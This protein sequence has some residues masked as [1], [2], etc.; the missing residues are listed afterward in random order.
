MNMWIKGA[1]FYNKVS[2]TLL[3]FD[4]NNRNNIRITVGIDF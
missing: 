4:G 3:K 1:Y 2:D